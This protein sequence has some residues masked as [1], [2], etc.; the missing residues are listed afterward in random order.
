MVDVSNY[1]FKFI[2]DITVKPEES[3]INLYA[4]KDIESDNAIKSTRIMCRI[5]YVKYKK[6]DLNEV[7]NKQCQKHLTATE[8]RALLQL[9]NK[10]ED[11][12]DGTLGTRNTTMVDL[13]L[14]DDV[15]LLCSRPYPVPKVH[16]TI[17]KKEFKII[18]SLVV[19]E[20]ANESEWGA[21]SFA[22]LKAKTNRVRF[23]SD[24]RNLNRQ[25]KRK[26][27]PMPKIHE[28]LL[29]LGGFKYATSLVLKM[30]YYRIH[31]R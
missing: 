7:M 31:I 24:I 23:L 25:L 13:E 17:K 1:N 20:E 29:N 28:M 27:Y 2:T 22:Q 10:F 15:K 14:K 8:R 6:A 9:L 11:L 4:E 12:F 19:P 16:K 3:F 5:L 18:A 30:G 21:T 26:P